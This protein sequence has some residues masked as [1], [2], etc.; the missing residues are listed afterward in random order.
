MPLFRLAHSI[1][2]RQIAVMLRL[3][4]FYQTY[5][6]LPLQ[7]TPSKELF[8]RKL[9]AEGPSTLADFMQFGLTGPGGFYRTADE[10]VVG[11]R[12][13]FFTSPEVCSI[14]GEL[15]A[16]WFINEIGGQLARLVKDEN[17][18]VEKYRGGMQLIELGPGRGTL[19]CDILRIFAKLGFITSASEQGTGPLSAIHLVEIHNGL[20]EQ[21]ASALHVN[22]LSFAKQSDHAVASGYSDKFHLPVTWHADL[23]TVPRGRPTGILAHEFFDAL[24]VHAF[25]RTADNNNTWREILVDSDESGCKLRYVLAPGETPTSRLAR[26]LIAPKNLSACDYFEVSPKA[27]VL[28]EH[29]ARRVAD[30]GGTALVADYGYTGSSRDSFRAF[31]RH[32]QVDPLERFGQCD[33]TADVDFD[34]LRHAAVRGASVKT[35]GPICQRVF[36]TNMGLAVRL[37]QLL[38]GCRN[39]QERKTLRDACA[40]LVVEMGEKF[41]FMAVSPSLTSGEIFGFAQT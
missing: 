41:H 17:R 2:R 8:I 26:K 13:E 20:I 37:K 18:S 16:L 1:T 15:I 11:R 23:A 34:V 39:D 27:A 22:N 33:L 12:G 38:R 32:E 10:P 40:R 36:L 6:N 5:D 35:A 3:Q 7:A 28:M 29:V 25:R 21:Q 19:L 9:R 31:Q 30:D 24:P 4:R 14:F